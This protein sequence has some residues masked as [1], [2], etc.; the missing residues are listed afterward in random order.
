MVFALLLIKQQN[1]RPRSTGLLQPV[2]FEHVACN[3]DSLDFA[4]AWKKMDKFVGLSWCL[5]NG[6]I[7]WIK[8]VP[9]KMDKLVG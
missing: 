3:H 7:C 6:Y 9:E 8:L 4:G 2:F 5:K 1:D